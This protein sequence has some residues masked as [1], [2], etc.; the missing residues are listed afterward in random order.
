MTQYAERPMPREGVYLPPQDDEISLI[1][2]WLVLVRHKWI[3][4]GLAVVGLVAGLLV[5]T[6]RQP[7]Y[8]YT[9][10]AEIGGW[11]Q[12]SGAAN[13]FSPVASVA[14][15]NDILDGFAQNEESG[16]QF[17][18]AKNGRSVSLTSKGGPELAASVAAAHERAIARLAE[19]HETLL[20]SAKHRIE[21]K[22]ARAE[23]RLARLEGEVRLLDRLTEA[24]EKNTL[25]LVDAEVA[26]APDS[27]LLGLSE[28]L[29]QAQERQRRAQEEREALLT[30]IDGLKLALKSMAPTRQVAETARSGPA[31]PSNGV[32]V[33]LA[34]VLGLFAGIF[35]AFFFEFLRKAREAQAG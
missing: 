17:A 1:D 4:M 24:F 35:G 14:M 3:V 31:G 16:F 5:A 12:G 19:V 9:T 20:D 26:T 11:W 30:E 29:F 2:L 10:T 21:G 27:P 28:R 15:I 7:V 32:I 25:K 8:T 6:L 34:A 23:T 22:L 18:V 33:T 13:N